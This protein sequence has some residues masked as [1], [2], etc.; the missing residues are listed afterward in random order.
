[1][2]LQRIKNTYLYDALYEEFG[3][4]F[5][6]DAGYYD[7]GDN[8]FL[9]FQEDLIDFREFIKNYNSNKKNALV[10]MTGSFA[11]VH[12]GHFNSAIL[13]CDKLKNEGYNILGIVISPDHDKYVVDNKIKRNDLNIHKRISIINDK[14]KKLKCEYPIICDIWNGYFNSTAINFTELTDFL[15]NGLINYGLDNTELFFVCGGDNARFAKTF[16]NKHGCVVIERPGYETELERVKAEINH[17]NP[18]APIYY[19]NGGMD[20]SSTKVRNE[21]YKEIIDTEQKDLILKVEDYEEEIFEKFKPILGKYYKSVTPVFNRDMKSR[22]YDYLDT[23]EEENYAIFCMDKK[24]FNYFCSNFYVSPLI[25]KLFC[26]DVSRVYGINGIKKKGYKFY[27]N[28]PTPNVITKKCILVDDDSVSGG[29]MD[30]G[31]QILESQG[32]EIIGKFVMN[33]HSSDFEIMDLGDLILGNE[34]GGLV[35]EDN[36]GKEKRYPYILPYVSPYDR[37]SILEPKEFTMDIIDLNKSIHKIDKKY[38]EVYNYL[39]N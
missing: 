11:P 18:Y 7:N 21:S 14:I 29:T 37:A 33:N 9:R 8:T 24:F 3:L 17:I 10:Y 35:I 39:K 38:I 4:D 15:A 22:L 30:F 23:I 2:D 31:S 13:A 36:V 19:V 26:L 27:G 5:I 16:I 20:I 34:I 1:M 28:V 12:D 6:I 25:S 32:F